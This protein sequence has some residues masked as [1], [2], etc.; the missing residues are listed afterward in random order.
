MIKTIDMLIDD[1]RNYSDPIGKIN[2]EIKKK[3]LFPLVKGLY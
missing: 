1:Y 2:R 3:N